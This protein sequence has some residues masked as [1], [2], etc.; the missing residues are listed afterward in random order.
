MS[1]I[2]NFKSEDAKKVKLVATDFD[3]TVTE[4]GQLT[5][6]AIEA[7]SQLPTVGIKLIIVTGRSAGWVNGLRNYL[8]VDGSIAENGGVYY[9]DPEASPDFLVSIPSRNQHRQNLESVFQQLKVSFPHLQE[10]PDNAF[11]FTDWTF[12]VA[13]LSIAD[14]KQIAEECQQQGYGFTYSSVQCHIKPQL[15]DKASGL[16]T[17]LKTY[18]PDISNEEVLTIGDSPNDE[19]LF[20]P[21]IFP[22]SVGVAN[23]KPYQQQLTHIPKYVT[24]AS[25]GKGFSELVNYLI[26]PF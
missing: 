18:F 19:S 22:I 26:P 8:P 7:I 10:S 15:Q 21:E 5:V 23:I 14:L 24:E 16:Q 1:P 12:D 17:V 20:N 3:G 6:A 11:R 13:G 4:K 2:A 9:H 25:E